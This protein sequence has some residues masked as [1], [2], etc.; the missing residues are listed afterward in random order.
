MCGTGPDDCCGDGRRSLAAMVG[1]GIALVLVTAAAFFLM[2]IPIPSMPV[3]IVARVMVALVYGAG[4]LAAGR[5][6]AMTWSTLQVVDALIAQVKQNPN[7]GIRWVDIRGP[8]RRRVKRAQDREGEVLHPPWFLCGDHAQ[9]VADDLAWLQADPK[10]TTEFAIN[11][12]QCFGS[13]IALKISTIVDN[14]EHV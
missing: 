6:T 5:M 8:T 2:V 9:I 7:W 11:W 4:L 1:M 12:K 14:V 10:Q 13:R 3:P